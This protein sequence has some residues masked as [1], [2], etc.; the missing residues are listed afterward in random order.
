MT[1]KESRGRA[2]IRYN[3]LE[4]MRKACQGHGM[5]STGLSKKTHRV[6]L[7]VSIAAMVGPAMSGGDKLN[8]IMGII[9]RKVK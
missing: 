5:R 1:S 2:S 3:H 7:Y 8:D 6:A 4:G 9:G